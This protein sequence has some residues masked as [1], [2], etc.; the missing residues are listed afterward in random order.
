[1]LRVENQAERDV[2]SGLSL[3]L[4]VPRVNHQVVQTTDQ[5]RTHRPPG[6]PR[7]PQGRLSMNG[8]HKPRRE[9][10]GKVIQGRGGNKKLKDKLAVIMHI[11]R[12]RN[13]HIA[14]YHRRRQACSWK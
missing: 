5:S 13:S 12:D 2:S 1:M 14:F 7:V 10:Q 11:G 9:Q 6:C 8:M 3:A 4:V